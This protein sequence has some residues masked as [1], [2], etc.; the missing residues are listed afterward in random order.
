MLHR[1]L[2]LFHFNY[3]EINEFSLINRMAVA[4]KIV[5]L[6]KQAMN[7]IPEVVL[8]GVAATIVASLAYAKIRYDYSHGGQNKR[9]KLIPVLMRPDDSRVPHVHKT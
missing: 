3:T 7:E 2:N 6:F 5:P 1:S 8:S 9:Y 4:G